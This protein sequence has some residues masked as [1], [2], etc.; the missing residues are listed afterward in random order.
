M[1]RRSA[2]PQ[3]RRHRGVNQGYVNLSGRIVYLGVWPAADQSPPEEVLRNYHRVLAEWHQRHW[4]GSHH[5]ST[6]PVLTVGELLDAFTAW[7]QNEFQAAPSG[8]K[9]VQRVRLAADPARRLYAETRASDFGPLA[10]MAVREEMVKRGW[11]RSYI[12]TCTGVLKR[13]WKWAAPRELVRPDVY[14]AL[15]AVEGLKKGR[16]P[17][18]EAKGIE[19]VEKNTIDRALAELREPVRTMVLVQYL[20]GMRP[21]EVFAMR[22]ELVDCTGHDPEGVCYSGLWVYHAASKMAHRGM[23]RVIFLGPQAQA[24]LAPYLQKV[25]PGQYLFDPRTALRHRGGTYYTNTSYQHAV[26]R[27]C[28]RAQVVPFPPYALR[29]TRATEIR[30]RFSADHARVVLGH[31]IGGTV[32]IYAEADREKA[33]EVMRQIG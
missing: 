27:A 12:N 28:R 9:T 4:T 32:R 31:A 23:D 5:L 1:P 17:A 21:S 13:A 14:A 20:A 25:P 8:Y 24:V 30:S 6:S 16:T 7:T 26:A 11:T 29:H 22:P 15:R 19:A 18:L 10:L 2:T 33:A 3:L